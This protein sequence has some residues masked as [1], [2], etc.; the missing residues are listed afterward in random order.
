M[1]EGDVKMRI[2]EFEHEGETV[3]IIDEECTKEQAEELLKKPNV[4]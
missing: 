4:K 3:Y 1:H 2:L